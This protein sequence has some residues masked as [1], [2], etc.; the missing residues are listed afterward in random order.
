M[1]PL[2]NA[3]GSVQTRD[4]A[5]VTCTTPRCVRVHEART[6]HTQICLLCMQCTHTGI[7]VYTKR[8]AIRSLCTQSSA[9]SSLCTHS[10]QQTAICVYT[11]PGYR[12][13]CIHTKLPE[14]INSPPPGTPRNAHP[15][16]HSGLPRSPALVH[17][18]ESLLSTSPMP[19]SC[20]SKRV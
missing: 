4:H 3:Y 16:A 10:V 18:A 19:L 6:V 15:T 9:N 7:C 8:S 13:P 5:S 12:N 14:R 1:C 20:L 11:E 17:A 2:V